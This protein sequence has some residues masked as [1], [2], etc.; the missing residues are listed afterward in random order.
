MRSGK[1]ACGVGLPHATVMLCSAAALLAPA[2]Y[3]QQAEKPS[4]EVIVVTAQKRAEDIQDV[5]LSVTAFRNEQLEAAGITDMTE[6][7]TGVAGLQIDSSNNQR[8]T[9]VAIRGIGSSGTNPGIEPSVGVF[10]DGVY[11]PSGGMIQGELLDIA[12][13]EILRGPQGTLYG[14]NTPVGAINITTRKPTDDFEAEVR[15]GAGSHDLLN[16]AGYVGGAVAEGVSGRV[17]GWWR[18]RGGYV[19]SLFTGE[20]TNDFSGKGLRGRLL[21]EPSDD[22]EINLIGHWSMLQAH[23]CV[24]EQIDPSG[25]QGIATPGFLAAQEALGFPFRNFDDHDFVVD[26]DDTG[27]DRTMTWGASADISKELSNGL[28]LTSIT[29]FEYWNN[30]VEIAVDSLPQSVTRNF[31]RQTNKSLSQEFRI[32]SPT[33]QTVEYLAGLFLY[34]QDTTYTNTIWIGSG[35]NRVF[36]TSLCGVA[37]CMLQEGDFGDSLF[38]QET[39]SAALFGTATWNATD[40]LSLTGGLRFSWDNK[41]VYIEHTNSPDASTVFNAVQRAYTPGGLERK[42]D[43][44][45]WQANAK[46]QLS[47]DVMLFATA[48]TGSKAGGFNSR[49]G[50]ATDPVEFEDESSLTYEAGLKSELFDRRLVLNATGYRMELND[51]QEAVLNPVTGTGFIVGN[52]GQRTVK[53]VELDFRAAATERLSFD[54]ALGWMD[55]EYTDHPSG[56]CAT[57]RTPDGDLPGTCNYNGMRSEKSPEWKGSLAA[58]WDQ[59]LPGDLSWT[60]RA[61]V[62]FTS[63]YY[64]EPTLDPLLNVDGYQLFNLRT[65][66]QPA[67]GSWKLALWGRNLT[68]EAYY[69]EGAPQPVRAFV[70]A[71]G[72]AGAGG[73]IG[74]YGAPRTYGVE[75]TLKY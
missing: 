63:N 34:G 8:N 23:C 5:P 20:D 71:G 52:A 15:L 28:Q 35:A 56:Q 6:L 59:P 14:R 19:D 61:E 49:R 33:G 60:T 66:L 69:S 2:A 65:T 73:Y 74:W 22:L 18:D 10:L 53:G 57:G 68:D 36:P 12:S 31:Q 26:A 51:F 7:A 16:A 21:F 75:L 44:V 58:V 25:P 54:G 62:T 11:L 70:S 17:S 3:A 24:G 67:D 1:W 37:P 27:N 64:V 43:N 4:V 39:R 30:N 42:E 29:A 45:T 38:E 72:V 47:D 40:R 50:S 32:A 13:V 46:Y 48:A 41:D 55:A 9:T